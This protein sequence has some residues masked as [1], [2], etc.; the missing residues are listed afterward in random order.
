MVVEEGGRREK[1]QGR[2]ES[3]DQSWLWFEKPIVGPPV[4]NLTTL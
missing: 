1:E 2:G 3:R 4:Y